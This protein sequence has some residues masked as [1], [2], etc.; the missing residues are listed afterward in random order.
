MRTKAGEL[1]PRRPPSMRPPL[2]EG[3]QR[4][5]VDLGEA[6]IDGR[7]RPAGERRA[8]EP[9]TPGE[10]SVTAAWSGTFAS[11]A[12]V[13]VTGASSTTR[14]SS[15]VVLVPCTRRSHGTN[16]ASEPGRL[17]RFARRRLSARR[18]RPHSR[19]GSAVVVRNRRR[20]DPGSGDG[21]ESSYGE[22]NAG[23]A[24]GEHRCLPGWMTRLA[25]T[26]GAWAPAPQLSTPPIPSSE[27]SGWR[28]QPGART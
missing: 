9:F 11:Y 16:T 5:R 21:S 22:R 14:S 4:N 24:R 19:R 28:T 13:E 23:A 2:V 27:W 15:S 18:S 26:L 8:L 1:S 17:V 3:V 20:C 12:S 25:P 10:A 7:A 6:C